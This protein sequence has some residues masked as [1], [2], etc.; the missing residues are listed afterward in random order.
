MNY[1]ICGILS[2]HLV[3]V[4]KNS[5]AK[6]LLL[7]TLES[8]KSKILDPIQEQPSFANLSNMVGLVLLIEPVGSVGTSKL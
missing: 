2:L 1:I 3:Y 5:L 8:I 4:K 7:C 6:N